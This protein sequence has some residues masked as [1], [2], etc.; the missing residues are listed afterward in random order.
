M[1]RLE[2]SYTL[3]KYEKTMLVSEYYENYVDFDETLKSCKVCEHYNNCWSCPPF[4]DNITDSWQNYENINLVLLKLSYDDFI[5]QEKHSKDDLDIILQLTLYNEKRKLL[6]DLSK[7]IS[8]DE[9][10][11]DTMILSTGYCNICPKCT[12]KESE[13]CRYPK[14]KLYSME[15]LGAL[16]S[17]T[18]EEVFDTEIKWIDMDNGI[19][20]EYLTLLMGVLY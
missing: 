16:V 18:T 11:T 8:D 3:K 7:K 20:P 4:E 15:S 5:T 12:R 13:P 10:L 2:K 17:K 6:Q 19:I 1:L 9:N 14:N